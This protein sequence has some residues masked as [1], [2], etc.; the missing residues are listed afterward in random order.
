M[1]THNT[2]YATTKKSTKVTRPFFKRFKFKLRCKSD[3]WHGSIVCSRVIEVPRPYVCVN[4]AGNPVSRRLYLYDFVRCFVAEQ[5]FNLDSSCCDFNFSDVKFLFST[6][7]AKT[8][9]S[10]FLGDGSFTFDFTYANLDRGCDCVSL[11]RCD[12]RLFEV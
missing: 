3:S 8:L 12:F 10:G 6:C 4:F 9:L 7:D 11:G 5:Y 2:H 1:S